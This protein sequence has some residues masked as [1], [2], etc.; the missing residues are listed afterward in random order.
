MAN[1]GKQSVTSLPARAGK[2]VNYTTVNYILDR[3]DDDETMLDFGLD[4]EEIRSVTTELAELQSLAND[5]NYERFLFLEGHLAA[6]FNQEYP[7]EE[8]HLIIW[9]KE[10][11]E[12][13]KES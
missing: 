12:D 5:D 11:I 10:D 8:H 6:L 9:M 4:F 1:K 3:I 13:K 7:Q 2:Y